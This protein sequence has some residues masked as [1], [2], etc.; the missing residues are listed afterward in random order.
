[1]IILD[2]KN[3]KR[4]HNQLFNSGWKKKFM[5]FHKDP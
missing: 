2:Q 4:L 3:L 5:E 1:M